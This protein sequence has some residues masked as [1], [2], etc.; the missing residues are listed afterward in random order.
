[1]KLQN[2]YRIPFLHKS[3]P[4]VGVWIEIKQVAQID[5]N[6]ESHSPWWEC[7]LK[8]NSAYNF[9]G[10]QRSLPLVGVWIEIIIEKGLDK[11][12]PGHSPW[13][14]CGLKFLRKLPV[15]ERVPSLPLVGVWI[16]IYSFFASLSGKAVTPL[17]GSVD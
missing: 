17:G 13:W 14:E 5:S 1:M 9:A 6:G 12:A 7:G 4:L 3:L 10:A 15:E 16:E 2:I 11:V 8:S